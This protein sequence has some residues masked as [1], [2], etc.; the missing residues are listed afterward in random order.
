MP[1]NAVRRVRPGFM[2]Y[3]LQRCAGLM[4]RYVVVRNDELRVGLWWSED[5]ISSFAE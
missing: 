1:L 4:M 3:G 5:W 2:L